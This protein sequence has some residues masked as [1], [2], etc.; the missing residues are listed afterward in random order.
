MADYVPSTTVTLYANVP[1]DPDYN[2][3]RW[4]PGGTIK[5]FVSQ[6]QIASFS[7][8]SYQRVQSAIQYASFGLANPCRPFSIRIEGNADD[9][10]DVNY[11]SFVNGIREFFCFVTE[12]NYISPNVTEIVYHVDWLHTYMDT[13]VINP[14][15]VVREHYSAAQDQPFANSEAEPIGVSVFQAD[16]SQRYEFKLWSSPT[17]C[18]SFAPDSLTANIIMGGTSAPILGGLFGGP[19]MRMFPLSNA[20]ASECQSFINSLATLTSVGIDNIVTNVWVTPRAPQNTQNPTGEH[21]GDVNITSTSLSPNGESYEVRNKKILSSPFCSVILM[22]TNGN[23]REYVPEAFGRGNATASFE[24]RISDGIITDCIAYPLNYNGIAQNFYQGVPYSEQ[25]PV[26]FAQN[27]GVMGAL[28]QAMKAAGSVAISAAMKMPVDSGVSAPQVTPPTSTAIATQTQ[29][30]AL[31]TAHRT[32]PIQGVAQTLQAGPA[33][34]GIPTVRA[35]YINNGLGGATPNGGHVTGLDGEAG[36]TVMKIVPSLADCEKLDSFFDCFGYAVNRFK[37]PTTDTRVNFNYLQLR[38][39]NIKSSAPS[40]GQVAIKAAFER[41][42]RLWHNDNISGG[43]TT[44]P[45][46]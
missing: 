27:S 44:N 13:I 26:P 28:A 17:I 11:L 46:K 18:V 38:Q 5:G 20:G 39:P 33:G 10:Y 21:L 43:P 8:L 3:V 41:G 29:S 6:F 35:N 34:Q 14:S 4:I 40:E 42:V 32:P 19:Y 15:F 9:Y 1:L 36:Y 30:L 37:N 25:V 7:P 45:A 24:I 31:P 12:V 16:T 2:D 23:S 22:C